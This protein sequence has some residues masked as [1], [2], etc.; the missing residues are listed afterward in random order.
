MYYKK[1][2]RNV[3]LSAKFHT[4]NE[5]VHYYI[6]DTKGEL[7]HTL[8][9]PCPKPVEVSMSMQGIWEIERSQV[10][11]L[12]CISIEEY[13]ETFEGQLEG[14]VTGPVMIKT[15]IATTF[16]QDKFLATT[17]IL[18]EL[19]HDNIIHLYG[20]CSREYPF[21]IITELMEHGTNLQNYL[22]RGAGYYLESPDLK[23]IAT[24]IA[25]GMDYLER[26]DYIHCD[27]RTA[28]ILVRKH[29]AII[30]THIVKIA[31]FYHATNLNGSKYCAYHHDNNTM[32]YTLKWM[33]PEGYT[34][35]RLGTKSDVWS[36]GILLWELFNKGRVPYPGMSFKEVCEKVPQNYRMPKPQNC[37]EKIYK[38]ML[39]CWKLND[40]ERP[41]FAELL[42]SF[43]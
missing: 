33:A 35:N 39:N 38:T 31:N 37:P 14:L 22:R 8:T 41:T 19:K 42:F 18:Q 2:Y 23:L 21:Y 16:P 40:N 25:K 1:Q 11:V 32:S 29:D 17:K 43:S 24:E 3:H 5:L 6:M 10:K 20:I 12:K 27:L 9:V 30:S 15:N 28:N 7:E 13:G 4:M 36:F 26:K 34:L